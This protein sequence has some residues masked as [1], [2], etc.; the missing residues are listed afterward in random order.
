MQ[1]NFHNEK[2]KMSD[3]GGIQREQFREYSKDTEYRN[4]VD[5]ER[6]GNNL[7]IEMSPGGRDWFA[8]RRFVRLA[9][10]ALSFV[11]PRDPNARGL[12]M[13]ATLGDWTLGALRR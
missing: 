3:V 10:A 12:R 13:M 1:Y 11:T 6:T 8:D 4:K 7:Y 9:R 5:P 2:Y